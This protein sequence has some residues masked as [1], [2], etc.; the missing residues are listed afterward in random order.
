V[1]AGHPRKQASDA[2]ADLRHQRDGPCP[3]YPRCRGI[4]YTVQEKTDSQ[5]ARLRKESRGGRPPGLDEERYK[6]R[7]TVERAFS[8]LNHAR[9]VA[10]RSA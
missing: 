9:A 5:A 2:T 7:H 1:G 10:T 6:K 8:R 4:R 3:E